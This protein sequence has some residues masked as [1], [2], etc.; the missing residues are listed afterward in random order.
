M[1]KI[2]LVIAGSFLLAGV[3]L[4]GFSLASGQ[5]WTALAL[6]LAGIYMGLGI[7]Q[8]VTASLD[9]SLYR[10]AAGVIGAIGLVGVFS[11]SRAFDLGLQEAQV[12]ALSSLAK[13]ELHCRAMTPE[14]RRVQNVGVA[15]CA[16]QANADQVRAVVELGKG[17]RLGPGMSILDNGVALAQGEPP[18][19][20][21]RAFKLPDQQCPLA[22]AAMKKPSRDALMK[23]AGP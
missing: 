11:Y 10:Y 21:A 13:M 14:M 18:N 9:N 3:V 12:D 23:A 5:A 7:W 16:T 1:S 8:G 15:A 22:F 4:A 19:Y 6:L 20:C 17:L 2:R